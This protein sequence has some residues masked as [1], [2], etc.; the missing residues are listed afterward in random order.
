MSQLPESPAAGW[1]DQGYDPSAYPQPG[2]ALSANGAAQQQYA[3]PQADAQW[4]QDTQPDWGGQH[5]D[6]PQQGYA[7]QDYPQQY[8]QQ[9]HQAQQ[10]WAGQAEPTMVVPPQAAADSAE[11]GLP[12]EFDHLFR[13]STPDSR[14]AIDRQ[15]PAVGG[16]APGYLNGV[17]AEAAPP[18]GAVAEQAQAGAQGAP[19]QQQGY[20]GFP[21]QAEQPY[22]AEQFPQ[23]QYQGAAFQSGQYAPAE[24]PQPGYGGEYGGAN[25]GGFDGGSGNWTG[26]RGRNKRPLIIGGAVVLVA[27]IGI[28]IAM[29]GGGGS[30]GTPTAGSSSSSSAAAKLTKQQQADQVYQ[31]IQQSGQL[32][33]DA[34]T[35]VIDVSGCKDLAGAQS[36]LTTTAQ[37]RQAQADGV[38][39]LDVSKITDGAQLVAQLQAAWNASAQYDNAFAQVA[40]DM[41]SGT[42]KTSA[43]KKDSNYKTASQAASAADT[44]KSS[45]ANLWNTNVAPLEPQVTEAKL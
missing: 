2:E 32:R 15:K 30:G 5:Q 18:Q 17:Q 43:V 11:A 26:G 8:Q 12:T 40:G 36:T 31:L 33:S 16:A 14:R 23:E 27:V 10:Q 4:Q 20:Q 6:Y 37:K 39:K 38:A 45:A 22:Q 44:A 29:S 21:Q 28:A 1:P 34:N 7:Q 41:Q 13:D 19:Y 42:C 9:G 25:N 24:Y 35:A 3:Q